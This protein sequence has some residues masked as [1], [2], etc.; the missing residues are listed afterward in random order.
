M[1]LY[2]IPVSITII[3]LLLGSSAQSQ[4]ICDGLKKYL[5]RA[6]IPFIADR[7]APIKQGEWRARSGI[8]NGKCTITL[9]NSPREHRIICSFNDGAARSTLQSH[10]ESLGTDVKSCLAGL[11]SRHEWRKRDTSRTEANGR[12]AQETTWIW[13]MLRNQTERQIRVSIH[14]GGSESASN[15]LIVIW[16]SLQSD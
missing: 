4:S 12:V 11:D 14:A 10:F 5:V 2:G 15:L 7:G 9:V 1:H 6:A 8:S 13:T 3:M 16:R